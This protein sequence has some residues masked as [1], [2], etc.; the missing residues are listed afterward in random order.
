MDY[1]R[2]ISFYRDIGLYDVDLFNTIN[3][4]IV[5]ISV[6]NE[7]DDDIFAVYVKPD[8]DYKIV[9]PYIKDIFDELVWVHEIAHII[10]I[11][12]FGSTDEK[13]PN[14]ME[15]MYINKYV[16]DKTE[17]IKRTEKEIE[18]SASEEHALAKKYKLS[19]ITE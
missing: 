16:E 2:I 8:G 10:D 18:E 9:L 12:R 5:V 11:H 17:I 3:K 15:S 6:E 7:E 4:K 19:K 14:L 13:F 1:S